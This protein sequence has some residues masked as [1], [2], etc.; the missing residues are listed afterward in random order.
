MFSNETDSAQTSSMCNFAHTNK[1]STSLN[2]GPT[3]MLIN[4]VIDTCTRLPQMR[5]QIDVN[6]AL[7]YIKI[8]FFIY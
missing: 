2:L 3:D 1:C 5:L 6:L 8:I 4:A 7:F